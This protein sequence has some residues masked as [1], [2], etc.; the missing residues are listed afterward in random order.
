MRGLSSALRVTSALRGR[1]LRVH[2][3]AKGDRVQLGVCCLLFVEVRGQQA[4]QIVMSELFSPGNERAVAG[5]LVMLDRLGI[6]N[7]AGIEHGLIVDLPGG[8]VSF[9][10][11][12]V[13]RRTIGALAFA[14]KKGFRLNRM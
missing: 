9:L 6:G 8:F 11:Q 3:L 10:D 5:N 2:T 4:N 14:T 13:D 12:A 1:S 7:D